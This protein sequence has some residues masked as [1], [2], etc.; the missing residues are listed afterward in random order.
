MLGKR[1]FGRHLVKICT[2]TPFSDENCFAVF[3]TSRNIFKTAKVPDVDAVD[4][5]AILYSASTEFRHKL[6][7]MDTVGSFVFLP[8]LHHRDF[9]GG[10]MVELVGDGV[11]GGFAP[12]D[13]L[14]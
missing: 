13:G 6:G 2:L 8:A 4:F 11:E 1:R 7:V 3:Y 9:C 10:K 14:V 12:G 5:H